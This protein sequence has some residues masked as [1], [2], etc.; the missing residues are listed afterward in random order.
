[1]S[2]LRAIC[3]G[4][5]FSGVIYSVLIFLQVMPTDLQA[6]Q[7]IGLLF[8]GIGVGLAGCIPGVVRLLSR[9][10]SFDRQPA[11]IA[12]FKLTIIQYA[13]WELIA[14][15]GFIGYATGAGQTIGLAL[16]GLA[17]ACMVVGFPRTE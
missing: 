2:T 3:L 17:I 1:M 9:A 13:L 14:L 12:L 5:I 16:C 10:F 15:L 4:F 11:P 6:P 8:L 7:E